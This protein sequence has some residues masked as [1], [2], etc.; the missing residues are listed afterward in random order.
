MNRRQLLS[1]LPLAIGG[2]ALLSPSLL[3]SCQSDEYQ[4]LFFEAADIGLLDE[5][6]ETILPETSDSPGAKTAK[7]GNFMDAYVAN[8]YT[9][10]QQ[11][12]MRLGLM[13][14]K[15]DCK[16]T[17]GKTFLNLHTRDRHDFL[18]QLDQESK[19]F[20]ATPERAVHYFSQ[21][22]QLTLF[23]YFTSEQGAKMALRYEPIPGKY[24]GDYPFEAGDKAWAL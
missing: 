10:E 24:I 21:L 20:K 12:T 11:G 9:L 17:K 23:A 15:D 13:K 1:T 16:R 18:V 19:D 8:C 22:K 14:F 5:I 4:G 7:V 2:T 3:I 6:G